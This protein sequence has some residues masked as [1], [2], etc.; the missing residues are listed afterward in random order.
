M[1]AQDVCIFDV[2]TFPTGK[3]KLEFPVTKKLFDKFE[4][5]D[6]ISANVNCN[7]V[8]DLT[9][10]LISLLFSFNGVITVACD[11]CL[12]PLALNIDCIENLLLKFGTN[13]SGKEEDNVIILDERE[14]KVDLS[15]FIYE[16]VLSQKPLRC[17]HGEI[18]EGQCNEEMI[19]LIKKQ[20][21]VNNET[22]ERTD[23]QWKALK[24]LK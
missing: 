16:N 18:G 20:S 2:R 5:E 23:Q 22:E 19:E 11:R 4:N 6:I 9:E 21:V 8:I 17:V 13:I 15:Q 1:I 24:Q 10:Q 3:S 14:T 12:E 7:V